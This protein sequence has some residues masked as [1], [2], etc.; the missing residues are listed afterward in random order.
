MKNYEKLNIEVIALNSSDV[1][2]TS[3]EVTTGAIT[4]PWN[5]GGEAANINS[6]NLNN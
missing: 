2:A 3:S 1:I 6:Y 4:M 5:N